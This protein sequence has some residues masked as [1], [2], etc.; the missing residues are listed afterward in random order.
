MKRAWTAIAVGVV[1]VTSARLG[2]AEKAAL[3]TDIQVRLVNPVE[4]DEPRELR[5]Q[6]HP[7]VGQACA[8]AEFVAQAQEHLSALGR[9]RHVSCRVD[10][11][12]HGSPKSRDAI[13]RVST[14][15]SCALVCDLERFAVVRRVTFKGLPLLLSA[16]ELRRQLTVAPGH[17]WRGEPHFVTQL[18]GRVQAVLRRHGYE[19]ANVRIETKSLRDNA[20]VDLT[21]H[22]KDGAFTRVRRVTV[23]GDSPVEPARIQRGMRAMCRSFSSLWDAFAGGGFNCYAK[24]RERRGVEQLRERLNRM[25]YVQ[26]LIRTRVTKPEESVQAQTPGCLV[27]GKGGRRIPRCVDLHVSVH[28]GPRLVPKIVL[29]RNRGLMLDK[30]GRFTRSLF[31]VEFFSRSFGGSSDQTI[32]LR[33]L[34]ATMTFARARVVNEHEVA[35]S[36][37]AMR[38]A[39]RRRGYMHAR[40][41]ALPIVRTPHQVRVE[42][43]VD[44]GFPSSVTRIQ[45]VGSP[46]PIG[47]KKLVREAGLVIRPRGSSASGHVTPKQLRQDTQ[48]VQSFYRSLG[49]PHAR[50]RGSVQ[51]SPSGEATL[52]Y[53]VN[54]PRRYRVARVRIVG[55]D[56]A[57]AGKTLS[58]LAH[59]SKTKPKLLRKAKTPAAAGRLC[60]T[61]PYLP[62]ELEQD[63][64]RIREIYRANGYEPVQVRAESD[65]TD[66]NAVEVVFFIRPVRETEGDAVGSRLRGND[67]GR[68]ENA[69][70]SGGKLLQFKTVSTETTENGLSQNVAS[71]GLARQKSSKKRSLL[72]VNEHFEKIF[73]EAGASAAVLRQ[74]VPKRRAIRSVFVEGNRKTRKGVMLRHMGVSRLDRVRPKDIDKGIVHLWESG[75]FKHID[76]RELPP[77]ALAPDSSSMLLRVVEKPSITW[78]SAL[79][80]STD[81]L[82][83]VENMFKESNLF[84]SMLELRAGLGWGLFWGRL[85]TADVTLSWPRIWGTPLHLHVKIPQARYENEPRLQEPFRHLRT[86]LT[87]MLSWELSRRLSLSCSLTQR[88]DWWQKGPEFL[89][90]SFTQDPTEALK[91]LDGLV[92]VARE[93]M[94]MRNIVE[95]A[96]DYARVDHFMNPRK[97]IR[98]RLALESSSKFL[99]NRPA[100]L[101]PKTQLTGYAPLGPLTL[102][103]RVQLHRA[104]VA[105]PFV[106]WRVL[107]EQS[108]TGALGGDTQV[109]AYRKN[110]IDV[111]EVDEAFTGDEASGPWAGAWRAL[112]NMELRFPLARRILFGDLHG[113]LFSDVGFVALCDGLFACPASPPPDSGLA[114]AHALGWS[115][116]MGLRHV[117]PIGPLT[118]DIA[119]APLESAVDGLFGRR[120]RVHFLFG[121]PF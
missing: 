78:E 55:G 34:H 47:I 76:V 30:A 118:V 11:G 24:Q 48:R 52:V 83:M 84:G 9:Y 94:A 74:P 89:P 77:L 67:R 15:A 21:V 116:G 40:I 81:D 59:C 68:S 56:G 107:K 60:V 22:I 114:S 17:V 86:D 111:G 104:F 51:M 27:R 33:E 109:R 63:A 108:G 43:I 82:F 14:N 95:P 73:N 96:L 16:R 72:E 112:G 32:L 49:Y 98:F 50:V 64:Q 45:L 5:E 65:E 93:P 75:L 8:A 38:H 2:W 100:F 121:Y 119:L 90:V 46:Q 110:D 23:E 26:A 61:S 80:F 88:F 102:V 6:L 41:H 62:H 7:F 106:N 99:G 115:V 70:S 85:T 79:S 58:A 10:P 117:L 57:L 39:L 25:G 20:L 29:Q 19:G 53:H 97:G 42:F 31:A 37:L 103:T 18:T 66:P 92:L 105:N 44:P 120:T 4:K 69:R 36:V 54:A 1:V 71:E 3:C 13:H 28:K 91:S 113:A 12:L 101:T 87:A 35:R